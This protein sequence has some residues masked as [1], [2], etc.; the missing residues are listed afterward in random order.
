M[1]ET[2][3]REHRKLHII[4]TLYTEEGIISIDSVGAIHDACNDSPVIRGI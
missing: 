4:E 2:E 3:E 1:K